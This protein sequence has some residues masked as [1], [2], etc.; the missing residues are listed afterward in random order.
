MGENLKE[1]IEIDLKSALKEK[2]I[3]EISFLRLLKNAILNKEIEKQRGLEK[4]EILDLLSSEMRILKEALES[5]KKAKREDL[6][7]KT[8]TEMEI[9]K[10]YLPKQLSNLELEK[11]IKETIEKL[12]VKDLKEMGKV[13]AI[14]M[15]QIKG[16]ADGKRV[17]EM[18]KKALSGSNC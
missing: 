16:R 7:K 11:L 15:P 17:A 9:L 18:V 13:M 8:E 4:E 12:K 3:P 14:L 10:R 5:F 1:K 2:K 6:I